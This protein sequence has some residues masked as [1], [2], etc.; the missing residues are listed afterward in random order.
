MCDKTGGKK[1]SAWK[2]TPEKKPGSAFCIPPAPPSTPC[3]LGGGGEGAGA[4]CKEPQE[5][6]GWNLGGDSAGWQHALGIALVQSHLPSSSATKGAQEPLKRAPWKQGTTLWEQGT[7]PWSQ[8]LTG[9]GMQCALS[10]AYNTSE[11]QTCCV[12][13][14]TAELNSQV[15]ISEEFVASREK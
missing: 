7:T 12:Q 14:E 10:L 5:P 2:G 13:L 4:P 11:S 15:G 3:E 1:S 8:R 6:F 9:F